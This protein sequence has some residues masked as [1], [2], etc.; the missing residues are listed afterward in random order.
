MNSMY[1]KKIFLQEEEKASLSN[2]LVIAGQ[3]E[4]A[5]ASEL[6]VLKEYSKSQIKQKESEISEA[7]TERQRVQDILAKGYRIVE[8]NT[9]TFIDTELRKELIIETGPECYEILE[10]KD[11]SQYRRLDLGLDTYNI[12][13]ADKL[14]FIE[15][16]E[17]TPD[18]FISL[19][20]ILTSE[21]IPNVEFFLFKNEE[22][23]VRL[24]RLQPGFEVSDM[25][26][27]IANYRIEELVFDETDDFQTAS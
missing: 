20:S 22:D 21:L 2:E 10:T 5:R 14:K 23:D 18:I 4:D 12:I 8:V 6:D 27:V 11:L 24:V 7:K 19:K 3:K 1:P 15:L 9:K 26:E 13:Q 16:L 17:Y 25:Q